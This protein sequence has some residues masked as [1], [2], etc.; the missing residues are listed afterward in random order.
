LCLAQ[1]EHVLVI[2]AK[3][4]DCTFDQVITGAPYVDLHLAIDSFPDLDSCIN[5][6]NKVSAIEWQFD[7]LAE[8]P[9]GMKRYKLHPRAIYSLEQMQASIMPL[10]EFL[11]EYQG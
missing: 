6:F 1:T 7:K 8:H 9:E 2:R 5:S 4:D 10:A 3:D 11:F